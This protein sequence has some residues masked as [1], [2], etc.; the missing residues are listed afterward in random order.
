MAMTLLVVLCLVVPVKLHADAQLRAM[1]LASIS[2]TLNHVSHEVSVELKQPLDTHKRMPVFAHRGFVTPGVI[3]NSFASFD[4]ALASD[5]PQIELDVRQSRDGVYYVSHDATLNRDAGINERIADL[6]SDQLDALHLKNGENVH[7]LSD[8]FNRYG[9]RM[10]YLV[11]FKDPHA[12]VNEFRNLMAQ[13]AELTDRVEVHS[14]YDCVLHR[15]DDV[16]PHM[17]KQL[18]IGHRSAIMQHINEP[19]IDSLA[20]AKHLATPETVE[21]IH[22]AGKEVWTWTVSKPSV[23]RANFRAGVDGVITDLPTAP[24]IVAEAAA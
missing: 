2:T 19:Y 23:I 5:C 15:L 16:M 22:N 24:K 1:T 9:S 6:S 18:L 8:V 20:L 4:A 13:H 7:R 12:N 10:Y 17:Y 14:F 11:E 21:R 3:E